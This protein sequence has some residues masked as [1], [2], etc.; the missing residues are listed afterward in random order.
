MSA[1]STT[2]VPPSAAAEQ[3]PVLLLKTKSTPADGYQ[4]FFSA[5][6]NARFDPIFVPVLEHRFRSE[7]LQDLRRDIV[8]G[9]FS[10]DASR[11]KY[12]AIIFTSQRAVEAFSQVV[13]ELRSEA[14]ELDLEDLLP[15][16]LP[17]Y[18]VGP[19]TARGLRALNLRCPIVG[20]ES[21][22]G[23]V[24]AQLI[25]E[26]Y[27][28]L[29][30]AATAE[31]K[32]L[33]ILFLVGEQRRDIIPKTLQSAELPEHQ[34][35]RV[36]EVVVYE[37]GEMQSFR[38]D[39]TALVKRHEE[40][41]IRQQWVVVFSPTGCRAMLESLGLVDRATGKLT[42]SLRDAPTRTWISTI[43]PTT[44]DYLVKNFDYEPDV[45]SK[46]PSP[47]GVG[48]GKATEP[49]SSQNGNGTHKPQDETSPQGT[50]RKADPTS[51]T[52]GA[53]SEDAAPEKK[54]KTL[55]DDV[56]VKKPAEEADTA[57]GNGVDAEEQPDAKLDGENGEQ[58]ESK[59]DNAV[60]ESSDREK[61]Q[62]SNILEKGIIY[63]FT[64]SRVGVDDAE[65]PDDLQRSYF[66]LRPLPKGAKL[67]DGAIEDTDNN[68]LFALPKKVLPKSPNDRFMAFVEKANASMKQLKDEFFAGSSHET[69]TRGTQHQS[70][71]TPLGE[72][73]YAIT[74]T[75]GR[76]GHLAYMLTIPQELGEVQHEMGIRNKGSFAVSV[77]NPTRKGPANASLPQ[78]PD[79]PQELL[80]E[81]R[82]L[83]WVPVQPKFLDYA[84]AQILLIGEGNAADDHVG[85]ALDPTRKDQKN[86]D[87][88]T[89]AEELE[90]LEHEDELRVQ[91]LHGDD[92]VFDDLKLNLDEYP[93]VPTTW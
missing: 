58:S 93:K 35:S 68:R 14:A 41:G 15:A 10:N 28:G 74:E 80:D 63:F 56:E 78:T 6:R 55:D 27:N 23:E 29:S 73:V 19:A 25:L 8:S 62:P 42:R 53:P 82:G 49:V 17:L 76:S 16:T 12:G 51:Q 57:D 43:G 32:R 5:A 26:H 13:A 34:R 38:A 40:A 22:N 64:R 46:K 84:N 9:G 88:E 1:T 52:K 36:D 39:F 30:S 70:P 31:G 54:Q 33:P 85:K 4:D 59:E 81:F 60:V 3:V 47:E 18:V 20:E 65:S 71:M 72:G 89:P 37:T 92:T 87:K 48:N 2:P 75:S 77:K 45:C 66:V 44:R 83:A 67:T 61:K 90:K 21:G 69:K 50:K 86:G 79:F 11:A 91:H 24:L 7:A